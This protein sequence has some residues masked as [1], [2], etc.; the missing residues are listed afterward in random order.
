[1]GHS[2]SDAAFATLC[3]ERFQRLVVNEHADAQSI[4][5]VL[6]GLSKLKHAPTDE[7]VVSMINRT[8]ALCLTPSQQPTLQAISNLL[9]AC[10][11]LRLAVTQAHADALMSHLFSLDTHRV[12]VQ[13][14]ANVAWS[15]AVMGLLKSQTF[16]LL[17]SR[18][19]TVQL[20]GVTEP[21][22]V[23]D[24]H[25]LYQGL[26]SLQPAPVADARQQ[27]V[28]SRLE[29]KLNNVGPRPAPQQEAVPRAE[30]VSAALMLLELAFIAP[31]L[32]CIAAI[33]VCHLAP[34]LMCVS[35]LDAICTIC[36]IVCATFLL[37]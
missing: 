31:D 26:D 4:A 25:Q 29:E 35:L 22:G 19:S 16:A 36:L 30:K 14:C 12:D 6:W 7:V 3:C 8:V 24:L 28:W 21:V 32:Q 18:L 23:L 34:Q 13:V 5:N 9:L 10:A 20:S 37:V 1:M 2:P 15:L 17:L 27:K 11:D 33:P